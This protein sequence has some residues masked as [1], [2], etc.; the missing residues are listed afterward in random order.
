M[1]LFLSLCCTISTPIHMN[2]G[3]YTASCKIYGSKRR[4]IVMNDRVNVYTPNGVFVGQCSPAKLE[5]LYTSFVKETRANKL[6]NLCWMVGGEI[7]QT[8]K[9][10]VSYALCKHYANQL[11]EQ[12]RGGLLLPVPSQLS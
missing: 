8:V 10:N 4:I 5:E 11:K 7:K 1:D 6:Y 3:T 12:Y 2:N 9:Q